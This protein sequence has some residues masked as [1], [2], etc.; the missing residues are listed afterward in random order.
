MSLFERFVEF[1]TT[2]SKTAIL[3][4]L[5]A[6]VVVGAGAPMVE[7]E[8]S[9]DQFQT[10]SPESEKLDF[11]DNNFATSDNTTTAQVIQRQPDGNVLDNESLIASLEYQ[12]TV[13]AD[14]RTA[15]SLSGERPTFGIANLIALTAIQQSEGQ[16]VR[17]LGRQIRSLNASIQQRQ[18]AL[19]ANQSQL[20]ADR[21]ALQNRS[22]AVNRTTAQLRAGLERLRANPNL[23]ANTVFDE[24][25]ANS[26]VGLNETDRTIYRQAARD[27]RSADSQEAATAAFR[28]GTQGV[29]ADD[30]RALEREQQR[31]TERGQRLQEQADQLEADGERLQSLADDLETQRAELDNASDASLDEQI[32]KLRSM[33]ASEIDDT[34]ET[35]LSDDGSQTAFG[36]MPTAYEPGSTTANATVILITQESEV[37]NAGSGAAS[38]TLTDA[39]LGLQTLGEQQADHEYLVFG[40]GIINDEISSS[41]QDSL[42]IVGPLAALF[43]VVTLVIAYRDLLDILLGVFGIGAVLAWTFGFMG[44]TG[45]NFNQ[46]FVAVPVLLI[47][48]SIDYA[49]HIFMRHREERL[50]G[51]GL[52]SRESMRV[53]LGGVGIALVWVT[54]TT[55][56]GF[57][58]NLTSPVPPIQDFGVVSSVGITAAFVV[59]AVLIPALKVEFDGLLERFGFNR[60]KRAFGTGGGL[61][62]RVLGVG[63]TAARRAPLVVIV[64]AVVVTGAAAVGGSQVDTSFEQS[65]FLAEQPPDW[66]DEL[67]EPFKPGEYTAKSNLEYVNE[68]FVRQDSQAQILL[69]GD[70][71]R[72]AA[73]ER[74]A[75]AEESAG[76]KEVTQTLSNGEPDV[77]SPLQVMESVAASNETFNRTYRAAD[78]DGDGVPDENVTAVYDTL[79][80]VAPDEAGN[81]IYR[82]DDG[83]YAALRVVVAIEGGSSGDATT[84]QMR[85]VASTADG[86]GLEVTATGTAIL[87]KIVQ[88]ELL[89]TVIESLV[90]TLVAV[91]LFLMITYRIT[92]GSATLGAVTLLP[93]AFSVAWIL[94]TMFLVGIPFNVL[95][96]LIT[97][98]TVGLGVAYSIHLSERYNQELEQ[99][100]DVWG[101]M[102]TAVTGTGGALLGSAATTV[103][104]FGTLA[105]AIL[106]PLQQFGIITGMTIVYAFLAAVLVLPSLLVV[107]TGR[108]GPPSAARQVRDDDLPPN[109]G[110]AVGTAAS[111][112]DATAGESAG[113]SSGSADA[114]SESAGASSGSAGASSA[115]ADAAS[116]PT[117][118]SGEPTDE[119]AV[120]AGTNESADRTD[121]TATDRTDGTATDRTD[122]TNGASADPTD[123]A[124]A[125]PTADRTNGVPAE[126]ET[127]GENRVQPADDD[128]FVSAVVVSGGPQAARRL[129]RTHVPPG[130]QVSVELRVEN[131]TGRFMIRESLDGGVSGAALSFDSSRPTPV[132]ILERA[133]EVSVAAEADGTARISYEI[134]VPESAP[135]GTRIGIDGTVMTSDTKE[136]VG[137][138]TTITVVTELFERITAAGE[139]TD[140]DLQTA[141]EQWEAGEITTD[142]FERVRRAWLRESN[143][144]TSLPDGRPH[145]GNGR[146]PQSEPTE[147][148]GESGDSPRRSDDQTH[149]SSDHRAD[150]GDARSVDEPHGQSPDES[151]DGLSDES[152]DGLSDESEDR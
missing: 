77:N 87:N 122:G 128:G 86:A 6:T 75:V 105:F 51:D 70:V 124:S 133:D 145:T 121:G 14:D 112:D 35:V 110:G 28:L 29:V 91:F 119:S 16:D 52:D 44:W 83:E 148:A 123:G 18:A 78:T 106:P 3:V 24:V 64:L 23:S 71:A 150:S 99:T 84:S 115:S 32:A 130:S 100:G 94:G 80:E 8:S 96:G 38:E 131:V 113:A 72:P 9:L 39:Q 146:S 151:R 15:D 34:I 137:G 12:Q 2:Y 76:E 40:A 116:D 111:A 65:D 42:L 97:S 79:F 21:A 152:H 41:Q 88:D 149:E 37:A 45:I 129:A 30:L 118:A 92:E 56:I 107:W 5:V 95:T 57:L 120:V 33:N 62:S 4:V 49:I 141:R 36:F 47:G 1:S 60:E 11:I 143:R 140:T 135:D 114:S 54:A 134:A 117:T 31:L 46:I 55:V 63:A 132:D 125:D 53:A 67:P 90:I 144:P 10:D 109:A 126:R 48:L 26:S 17:R 13:R 85:D 101:S 102:E 138:E 66:M 7:Q 136:T 82:T 147:S 43:V 98:L 74:I 27:L 104:G 142:A 58:S 139:V 22:A 50:D 25:Q 81:V 19:E 93:V 20:A 68:N 69:E 108:F 61:F 127:A 103:G 73:L 89:Q 59:F